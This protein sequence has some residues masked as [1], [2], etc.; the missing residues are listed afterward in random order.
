MRASLNEYIYIYFHELTALS[1]NWI[2][3][4]KDTDSTLTNVYEACLDAGP[5]SC[6]MYMDTVDQIRARVDKIIEDVH[7]APVAVFNDSISSGSGPVFGSVDYSTV[8]IGMIQMLYT[9]YASAEIFFEG[10]AALEQGNAD[11]IYESSVEEA[12]ANL[13]LTCLPEDA[14]QPYVAGLNEIQTAIAC[15]DQLGNSSI[16][17]QDLRVAYK[18]MRSFSEDWASTWLTIF[19]APCS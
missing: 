9:P 10:L 4:L 19:T 8:K 16:S 3:N 1:G 13:L 6:P 2:A 5:S 7:L 17:L 18:E 12:Y 11:L 15:G 14:S